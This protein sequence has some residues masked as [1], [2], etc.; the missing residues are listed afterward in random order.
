[1]ISNPSLRKAKVDGMSYEKKFELFCNSKDVGSIYHSRWSK[2][3]TGSFDDNNKILVK[4]FPYESI[5]PGSICKTEF[6][7][8]LNDRRIR[9]EFKSQEK[10]GSTDEKK[11]YLLENVRYRF[12]EYEIIIAILGEGWRSGMKEYIDKQKFRHK[13][14][15]IFYDYNELEGYVNDIIQKSK[16]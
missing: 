1:M 5:Y 3:G 11:P 6:V 10:A 4:E 8:I 13:K 12:R 16:I 15:S 9:I 14:V 7:L 2:S